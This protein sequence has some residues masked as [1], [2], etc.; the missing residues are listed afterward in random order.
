M[1]LRLVIADDHPLLI[2]GLKRVLEEIDGVKV[3]ACAENG[4][5]LI[6]ILRQTPADMV[7]LDLQMPKLDGIDSLRIIKKDFP[8]LKIIV[9]TNYG[10]AKLIKEIKALGADGFLLKDSTS[11]VLKEAVIA[12]SAGGAWFGNIQPD[13]PNTLLF[14]NEF[15]KK[16]QLTGRETEIICKIAEGLTSKEIASQ[17][18]V[19]EFTINTHRRNICRKLNIYTPVGLLNFAKEHGLV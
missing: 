14:T 1:S 4:W 3:I 9:F 16:Y 12:V 5:Q 17:L 19:S 6:S 7:L 8:K 2:D 18:F 15:M 11:T 10:Q 13:H